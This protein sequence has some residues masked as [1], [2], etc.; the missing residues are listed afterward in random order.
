MPWEVLAANTNFFTRILRDYILNVD[1]QG[2]IVETSTKLRIRVVDFKTLHRLHSIRTFAN[3][4]MS[5]D[6][7]PCFL[8]SKKKKTYKHVKF[9]SYDY[10]RTSSVRLGYHWISRCFFSNVGMMP[11]RFANHR[12]PFR[13]ACLVGEASQ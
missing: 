4:A 12:I 10:T 8:P 2:V 7:A 3:R 5:R 1:C 13:H 9:D 6:S 11:G